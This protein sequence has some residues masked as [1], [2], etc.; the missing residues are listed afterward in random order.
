MPSSSSQSTTCLE[1][2]QKMSMDRLNF[3]MAQAEASKKE[4]EDFE[5]MIAEKVQ[6]QK[7]LLNL[8]V[9]KKTNKPNKDKYHLQGSI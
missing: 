8:K 4:G 6:I 1:V 7:K 2:L 9:D 5:S 3:D